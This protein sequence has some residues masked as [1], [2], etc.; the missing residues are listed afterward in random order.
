MKKE[1]IPELKKN[2]KAL[3]SLVLVVLLFILASYLVSVFDF[4]KHL[5]NSYPAV[6]IYIL[7]L[8]SE[9][10]FAPV[11]AIPFI[12]LASSL[13]GIFLTIIYTTIGWSLGSLIAFSLA[14]N[15]GKPLVEKLVSLKK[16]EAIPEEIPDKHLIVSLAILKIV[17]PTDFLNYALGF[18]T[19]VKKFD[20]FIASIISSF[21][22]ATFFSYIGTIDF[23]AQVIVFVVGGGLFLLFSYLYL[24]SC[25]RKK[26]CIR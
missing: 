24:K 1:C 25:I 2:L 20:F 13:F 19:S 16:T 3:T 14:Q 5:D 17:L 9:T 15:Y 11:S 23:Y 18:L 7:L 12:P 4:T 22:F 21:F 8:I 10:V 6:L 26:N